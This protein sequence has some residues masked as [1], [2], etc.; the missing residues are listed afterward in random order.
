MIDKHYLLE[1][2][3]EKV[4]FYFRSKGVKGEIEKWV[5]FQKLGKNKYNLAFGDLINGEL[6]DS[7]TSNNLDILMVISTVSKTIYEFFELHPEVVILIVPRNEK[8]KQFYNTIF[9]RR[10]KE[11]EKTFKLVGIYKNIST[12]YNREKKYDKFEIQLK[13]L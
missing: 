12:P 3:S 9:R 13:K 10:Y 7:V 5:W 8:L 2:N 4:F 6:N 11:V 1:S